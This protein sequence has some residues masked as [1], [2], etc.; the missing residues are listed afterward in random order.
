MLRR[1]L[2]E[3]LSPITIIGN[4]ASVRK[5]IVSKKTRQDMNTWL[6]TPH[7]W[8]GKLPYDRYL[9]AGKSTFFTTNIKLNMIY[10]SG[11]AGRSYFFNYTKKD[12]YL[13]NRKWP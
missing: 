9:K 3:A 13:N 2:L 12:S 4:G 8:D 11:Q 7:F 5:S 6:G 10:F 1:A